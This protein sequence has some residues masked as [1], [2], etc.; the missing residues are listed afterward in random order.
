MNDAIY[1][2]E[3]ASCI[4]NKYPSEQNKIIINKVIKPIGP[5]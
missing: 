3:I 5:M 1:E 4:I 2:A